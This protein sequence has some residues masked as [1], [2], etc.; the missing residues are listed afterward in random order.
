MSDIIIRD[1]TA[2]DIPAIKDVVREVWDWEGFLEDDA[3]IDACVAVY[4]SPVLHEATFARAAVLN[5]KVAGVIFGVADGEAPCY[6]HLL[7]DLT[8]YII[9][10]MQAKKSDRLAICEYITRLK[11]VYTELI[12]GIED[13]YDGTLDFLVLSKAAQGKGIGKQLWLALKDY[14]DEKNSSKVYLYSDNECNFAFYER[15]GFNRRREKDIL[16]YDEEDVSEQYLYE[17]KLK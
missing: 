17:Y 10:L 4:F 2:D 14:F 6:K 5:G 16:L 11:N 13:D 3:V 1:I 7:E 8:P 15:Q 9:T 12:D